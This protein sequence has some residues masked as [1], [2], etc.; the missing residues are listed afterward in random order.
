MKVTKTYFM[1]MVAD[2]DRAIRFYR[3]VFGLQVGYRT[4]DWSELGS[5]GA[6]VALHG[7]GS[8]Q[9]R[10]TGLGFYVDDLDAACAAVTQGGGAIVKP[11]AARPGE[12]IRLAIVEDTEGNRLSLA[13]PVPP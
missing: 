11:P 7:G 1:V 12:P 2:M 8:S 5:G 6:T 4:P 10:D 3:D 9:A 13:E